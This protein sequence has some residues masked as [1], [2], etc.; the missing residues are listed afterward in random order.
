[1]VEQSS[2]SQP[3]KRRRALSP[4]DHVR[5]AAEPFPSR[6]SST[7]GAVNGDSIILPGRQEALP[8]QRDASAPRRTT[9]ATAGRNLNPHNLPRSTVTSNNAMG[10]VR[11]AAPW[12]P[13]MGND[14]LFRPWL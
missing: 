8:S 11:A 4:E 2:G 5:I 3:T 9:R 12:V 14:H 13:E 10:V 1:M 6:S 7:Q